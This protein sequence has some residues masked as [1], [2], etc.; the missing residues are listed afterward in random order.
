[1]GATTIDKLVESYVTGGVSRRGFMRGALALGL[2]M[3]AIGEL[4]AACSNQTQPGQTS[5][6]PKR[7]GTLREGYDLDFSRMDPINTTWYDPGFFAL[8]DALVTS[9]PQGNFVSQL[10][11][12][13]SFSP[14]GKTATF[15]IRSGLKF[16]SG[17]PLTAAAIKE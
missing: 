12:K 3:S 9:D 14:D 8:Y 1:M 13:W 11:E 6:T 16:H 7:G 15:T 5:G 10:A 4:L 17:R 2:S